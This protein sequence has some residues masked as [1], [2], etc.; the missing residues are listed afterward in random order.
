MKKLLI[1]GAA[2]T[3]LIGTHA[4]AALAGATKHRAAIIK[5]EKTSRT[6]D[7]DQLFDLVRRSA[8]RCRNP[9]SQSP[10]R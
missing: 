3:T 4:L 5:G 8:S 7:R 10:M 2:L 9:C 6:A 1:A